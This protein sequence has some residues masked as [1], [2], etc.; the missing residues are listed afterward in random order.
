MARSGVGPAQHLFGLGHAERFQRFA[1]SGIFIAQHGGGQQ[2]RVDRS[3]LADGQR[4]HRNA[5]RHL[6]DG[7]QRIQ[8]VQRLGLHRYAQHRQTSLGG[9]HSRQVSGAA[10]AGDDDLQAAR[11]RRRRVLEQQIRGAMGRNDLDFEGNVQFFQCGRRVFQRAPIGS[12]AHDQTNQGL[13]N[14]YFS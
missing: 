1:D 8:P 6:H 5:A 12:G 14:C 7:E 4:A 9:D 3:G 11:L 13:H 2:R 10:G